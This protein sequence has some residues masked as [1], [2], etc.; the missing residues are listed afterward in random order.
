MPEIVEV[1]IVFP[2]PTIAIVE[3]GVPQTVS[4]VEIN[5]G[6]RGIAGPTG[7][8]GATGAQGP[9]GAA[10]AQGPA[11]AT[12]A[13]GAT[14]PQGPPQG[15][16]WTYSSLT[17]GGDPSMGHLKFDNASIASATTLR[18]SIAD[19]NGAQWSGLLSRLIASTSTVKSVIKVE[20]VSDPTAYAVFN[21]TAG[22]NNVS[23]YSLTVQVTSDQNSPSSIVNGD[24]V[25]VSVVGITGNLGATGATGA[26]GPAGA[27][28]TTGPAGGPL[29]FE[30]K[31]AN[32]N[33]VSDH[34]Y[35]VDTSGGAI[36]A[37]L[38]ASPAVGDEIVFAD[39]KSTWPTI[40]LT[41]GRNGNLIDSNAGNL[42]CDVANKQIE[43]V[44]VGGS[45]GWGV[46]GR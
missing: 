16:V 42:I 32:F 26:T 21:I 40:N 18:I 39:A 19:I 1:E 23:Y 24:A 12:G 37:T 41:L 7:N 30:S 38:P 34:R 13:T 4:V 10:G 28:G 35:I 27:T 31:N 9:A 33:A 45:V 17:T 15:V 25:R 2:D 3:V 43:L 46:Y 5:T 6:P 14:G 22:S 36:T 29:H 11:G 44:W 20:K 8:T